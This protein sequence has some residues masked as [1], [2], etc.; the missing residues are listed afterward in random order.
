MKAVAIFQ[1]YFPY[2]FPRALD[3]VERFLGFN[4]DD[5]HVVVHPRD[6]N[7]KLFPHEIDD[8]LSTMRLTLSRVSLP[9]GVVSLAV[10]ERSLDRIEVRVH[11]EL[12]SPDDAK[13]VDIQQSFME[14]AIRACNL[15]LD[16]CRVAARA[17]FLAGV[18]R[19]YRPEDDQYY[20]LTPHSVTWFN[21]EDG[22][23]VPAYRGDVNGAASSGAI[24]SPERGSV[25][26]ARIEQ[27]FQ[28]GE[29]PSLPLSLLV[30]AEERIVTLRLREAILALGTGLEV[31][32]NEYIRRTGTDNDPQVKGFL[33]QRV[34]FG[35]KRF[36][37]VPMHVS[38]RSLK[39]EDFDTFDLVEKAYR[40]R[41]NV[42]HEGR[43]Y[44]VDAGASITVDDRLATEFL[45]ASESA[46]HW[47]A[48]L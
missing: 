31:A 22:Q 1:F 34:S 45:V 11:G 21:E 18:E 37:L 19:H 3:W 23:P 20:V 39:S 42:V 26:M 35:E 28:A 8:T 43:V 27:S 5:F 10:R 12:V 47:L 15:F 7:E 33:V 24:R 6:P 17:P 13:R 29:Q 40:T 2:V 38:G 36:H 32:S 46:V 44:Y 25:T 48:A 9:T 41:N 14:V 4:F 30:D 16:H